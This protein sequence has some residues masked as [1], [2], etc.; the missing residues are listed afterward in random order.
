MSSLT[1]NL[2]GILCCVYTYCTPCWNFVLSSLTVHLVGILVLCLHLLYILLECF[3]DLLLLYILLVFCVLHLLY[4]LKVFL[5]FV[6]LLYIL[7][8]FWHLHLLYILLVICVTSSLTV[9][10]VGFSL[11]FVFLLHSILTY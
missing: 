2:V 9:N 8:L 3:W 4:I 7:L 11:N 10:F 6:H 1:V 5:C